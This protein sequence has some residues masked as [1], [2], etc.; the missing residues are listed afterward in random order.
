M[1]DVGDFSRPADHF[2]LVRNI[3]LID[4]CHVWFG[5]GRNDEDDYDV[6]AGA[7]D[8]TWPALLP[9]VKSAVRAMDTV[10]KHLSSLDTGALNIKHFVISGGSKRGWTTWMMS[11]L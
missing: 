4:R 7:P 1:T 8:P 6:V 2:G 3:Q 11:R 5:R 9:M 10:Q